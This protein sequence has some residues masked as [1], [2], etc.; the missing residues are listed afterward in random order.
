MEYYERKEK[1]V[2]LQ[3]KIQSSNMLN[4]VRKAKFQIRRWEFDKLP[5]QAR[6]KVLKHRDDHVASVM[7]EAKASLVTITR[8]KAKYTGILQ[9]LLTQGVTL[10]YYHHCASMRGVPTSRG[11]LLQRPP[12]LCLRALSVA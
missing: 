8:D 7:D 5:I 10:V 1:Q 4:A 9:Q 12:I 11:E 2:D 3:K 6:L